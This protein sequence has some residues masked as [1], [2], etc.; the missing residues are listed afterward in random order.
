MTWLPPRSWPVSKNI[1][2]PL[3]IG[4]QMIS[5]G[6][7]ME[8]GVFPP[9]TAIDPESFFVELGRRESEVHQTI[10]EVQ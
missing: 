9:E 5:R 7:V 8:R 2:I 3:G 10:E 1:A 4:V 6:D